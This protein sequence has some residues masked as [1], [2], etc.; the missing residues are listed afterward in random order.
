MKPANILLKQDVVKI[1]DFGLAK[2]NVTS[3]AANH[4]A[5]IG[6]PFYMS[7]EVRLGQPYDK[8][9][10]TFSTAIILLQLFVSKAN[11]TAWMNALK[12]LPN[13]KTPPPKNVE[14]SPALKSVITKMMGPKEGRPTLKSLR[15]LFVHAETGFKGS[16]HCTQKLKEGYISR[17]IVR[18]QLPQAPALPNVLKPLQPE[19]KLIGQRNPKPMAVRVPPPAPLRAPAAIRTPAA[20]RE[21]APPRGVYLEHLKAKAIEPKNVAYGMEKNFGKAKNK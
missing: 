2:N 21:P 12:E 16:S 14:L 7:P 6:T 13:F 17:E 3:I 18:R 4:T 11:W 5:W 1:A 10:D 19:M 20:I 15:E 9:V 8:S